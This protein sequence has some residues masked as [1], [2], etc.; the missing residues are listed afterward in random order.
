MEKRNARK[1][2]DKL[3]KSR[4][5]TEQ[6]FSSSMNSNFDAQILTST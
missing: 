2:E 1:E 5:D 6:K 4:I 3:M